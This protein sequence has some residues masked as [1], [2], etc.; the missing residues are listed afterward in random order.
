VANKGK[1]FYSNGKLLLS[2]EYLVL[3]GATALALPVNKGQSISIHES[4]ESEYL[5]WKAEHLHGR[6]FD[7]VIDTKFMK[8]VET[9]DSTISNKLIE[10][11]NVIIKLNPEFL[12]EIKGKTVNTKLDFSPEHG[13]GSSSTLI[14]NL[15]LWADVDPYRLQTITFGGSGY[16]IACASNDKAI[17]YTLHNQIPH[18]KHID[19]KPSFGDSIYFVY[20][21]KKQISRDSIVHFKEKA[22]YNSTDI[23][24]IGNI[25][26]QMASA[27]SLSQF[28]EL[29]VEHENIISKILNLKPI[30]DQ[31][32]YDFDGCAKSLGGWGGDFAMLST[33]MSRS[34]LG[35]YLLKKEMTTFYSLNDISISD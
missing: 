32:F 26:M 4:P 2:G 20:L 34:D 12:S 3:E 27:Q 19:F 17:F 14:N 6:W 30:K 28:E 5:I 13:L 16:D 33:K 1:Y 22:S 9:D 35:D 29:I 8:I 21:G 18:I 23:E 24:A 10:I 31:L 7:A 25:S 15:A 11:L